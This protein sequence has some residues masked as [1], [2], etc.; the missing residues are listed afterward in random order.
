MST[1]PPS[2][3]I[4][5]SAKRQRTITARPLP[6]GSIEVLAPQDISDGDLKPIIER[7]TKRLARREQKH[8]LSDADLE[9]RARELNKKH[10]GG[11]LRWQSI[12]YVTNQMRRFGSCTPST[13]TIRISSRLASVPT[14]VLDYV[15]VHELAHL[16]QPNHS[17]AFWRLVARYPLT[18][19][20]RGYLMALGLDAEGDETAPNGDIEG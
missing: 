13:G 1:T 11:R 3:K 8:R 7:L 14:W 4:T 9:Q 12:S 6:D 16:E 2:I 19:R 18:E 20:A 5:R 15:I 10:F 17:K